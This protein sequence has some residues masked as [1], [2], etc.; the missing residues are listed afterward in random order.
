ML[1]FDNYEELNKT[2]D[3]RDG[4]LKREYIASLDDLSEDTVITT[5]YKIAKLARYENM[6]NK[7]STEWTY[8][9]MK[10][11]LESLES[12]T[13]IL[14]WN[15]FYT[16]RD[17]VRFCIE[18]HEISAP[19]FYT[20]EAFLSRESMVAFVNDRKVEESILTHE[21]YDD[22]LSQE[23]YPTATKV[24]MIILWHGVPMKSV[25]DVFTVLK[26][27]VDLESQRIQTSSVDEH[28]EYEW[29]NLSDKE[30][31]IIRD[32]YYEQ[33]K[34]E[35]P[36]NGREWP[37]IESSFRHSG[38]EPDS[39]YLCNPDSSRIFHP[40]IGFSRRNARSGVLHIMENRNGRPFGFDTGLGR[41][42]F[43]ELAVDLNRQAMRPKDVIK[44]G[45][46]HRLLL[47]YNVTEEDF[48]SPACSGEW[49]R[50][51]SQYGTRLT[52]DDV[53]AAF[54]IMKH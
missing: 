20:N 40:A 35:Y 39:F 29:L 10:R 38:G 37:L 22:I 43:Y 32:F 26:D 14:L 50:Y 54:R 15:D 17:Y 28:G 2:L 12:K 1:K 47:K 33:K 42:L 30:A 27:V 36:H 16:I 18:T 34:E 5:F 21:D 51:V 45:V 23:L 49:R 9:D 11:Y 13:T 3:L 19:E 7:S 48:D 44:S 52:K 8:E 25:N 53:A 4:Q 41:K 31:E 24:I 46:L 6:V